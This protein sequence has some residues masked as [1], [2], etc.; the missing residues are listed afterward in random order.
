MKFHPDKQLPDASQSEREAA[1]EMFHKVNR[2]YK[3]LSDEKEKSKYDAAL[4]GKKKRKK[5]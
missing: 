3:V 5:R 2:A 4:N 1:T